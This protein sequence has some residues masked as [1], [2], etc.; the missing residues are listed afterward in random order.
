MLKRNFD[1]VTFWGVAMAIILTGIFV[2]AYGGATWIGNYYYQTNYALPS[3]KIIG[4]LVI[5]A[6]G[7]IILE[8]EILRRK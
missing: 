8:L 2:F 6:L 5:M 7:Y 3:L 4:G 1:T